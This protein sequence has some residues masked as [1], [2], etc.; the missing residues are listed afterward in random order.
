MSTQII[1]FLIFGILFILLYFF[2]K[3][4]S[5][6]IA[7]LISGLLFISPIFFGLIE[8]SEMEGISSMTIGSLFLL[9]FVFYKEK[10][11]YFL[12]LPCFYFFL[13]PLTFKHFLVLESESSPEKT[14]VLTS[15][16]EFHFKNGTQQNIEIDD[17][18]LVNNTP[19]KL[20]IEKIIYGESFF[21]EDETQNTII[22]SIEPF[23]VFNNPYYIEYYFQ[24][25]PTT[26][27]VNVKKESSNNKKTIQ[28]WLHK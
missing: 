21:E 7:L 8:L 24:Q 5:R 13:I 6:K 10:N 23:S 3:S 17:K 12:L 19:N 1:S 16:K 28:Y 18:V 9:V 4:E 20:Y 2:Y 22:D 26:I 15:S 25:P 11:R 14:L 27:K